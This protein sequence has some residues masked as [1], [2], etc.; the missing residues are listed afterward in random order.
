MQKS[1]SREMAIM[2]IGEMRDVVAKKIELAEYFGNE[3]LES[4]EEQTDLETDIQGVSNGFLS[5]II[6]TITGYKMEVCGEVE[7]MF[8]C[9]CCGFRTLTEIYNP[10]EGTGYE[11]CPYCDWE[12]DGTKEINVYRSI[13]KGSIEDYRNNMK[14]KFNKYF[15]NKWFYE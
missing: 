10:N 9:P 1:I 5:E 11:I 13:N 2:L 8:P 4:T 12:D 7:K 3:F 14:E 15:I 6:H